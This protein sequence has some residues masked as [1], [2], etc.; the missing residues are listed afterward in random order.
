[1]PG[2]DDAIWIDSDAGLADLIAV[3]DGEERWAFDTEFHREKTYFPQLALLQVAWPDGIALVDPLAIDVAPFAQALTSGAVIV[4]HAADQDL[5]VLDRACGVGPTVLFDTQLAA[6]FCGMGI[7]SLASLAERLLDVRIPKGDRLT[8]WSRRPLTPSQRSYAALDVAY[9]LELHTLLG[10]RLDAKERRSWAED[11]CTLLLGRARG[12]HDP[13]TAWWRL[14]DTRSLKGQS[15]GVAQEV[16]AWRDHRAQEL[17]VPARYVL[18]DLALLGIAHK[19]PKDGAAL[20]DIRGLDARSIKAPQQES[21]MAAVERGLHLA[22]E[23]VRL[24]PM[25]EGERDLRAAVSLAAAWIAQLGRDEGIDPALLATR[26][27]IVGLLS[28]GRTR[29]AEGW[30]NDLV[31]HRVRLLAE[32]GASLAFDGHGGL[33][34]EARSGTRI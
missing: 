20:G 13:A 15:R 5:E 3:L 14:K 29:L 6:G 9:L 4:A 2:A 24:P 16:A 12:P 17:D 11:E 8:D 27:D 7:P 26:T 1:M 23:D 32:G 18:A 22:K 34:L 10:E 19:P 31:G 33:V 30:R 25:D 28:G 21:L